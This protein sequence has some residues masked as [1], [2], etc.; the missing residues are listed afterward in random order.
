MS[1]VEDIFRHFDKDGSGAIDV[2]ELNELMEALG[3]DIPQNELD[4]ALKALDA[5]GN[6]FIDLAEF[7][8]WWQER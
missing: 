8:A 1:E 6:G 7:K 5:D 4:V 3:A 2:R